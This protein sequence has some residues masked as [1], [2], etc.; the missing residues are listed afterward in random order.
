[1]PRPRRSLL[2][3]GL[4]LA[5]GLAAGPLSAQD[6]PRPPQTPRAAVPPRV[7]AGRPLTFGFMLDPGPPPVVRQVVARLPAARAGIRSGDVLLSVDGRAATVTSIRQAA[8]RATP[9]DTIRFR[10]RRDGRERE[11]A[12][13]AENVTRVVAAPRAPMVVID[14]DSV[15]AL[16]Q[17]YLDG[18]REAIE[19]GGAF[20]FHF[21]LDLDHDGKIDLDA[22]GFDSL[23]HELGERML[24]LRPQLEALGRELGEIRIEA[25]HIEVQVEAG[26][27][28]PGAALT[29][30]DPDL[31]AYFPGT[32]GGVLVLR[33]RDGSAAD[34]AGFEAGDVIVAVDGRTVDDLAALRRALREAEA[35]HALTVVRRGERL[36]LTI[37][38]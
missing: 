7:T 10:I 30:L 22:F 33:L 2:A 11:V 5:A 34:E 32:D 24:L 14:P 35:P 13:V 6:A 28:V 36:T 8:R 4:A 3:I 23:G 37:P 26:G 25:P 16:V 18:A 31:A 20:D 1:M 38:R 9:G 15:K 29:D 27:L 12:V 17:L 21:D 19:L